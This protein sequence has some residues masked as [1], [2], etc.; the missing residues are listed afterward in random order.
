MSGGDRDAA[1]RP[2]LLPETVASR[3]RAGD[4][5][6]TIARAYGVSRTNVVR[7]LMDAGV[8]TRSPWPELAE[9]LAEH[10]PEIAR[11]YAAG[12]SLATLSRHF[13]LSTERVRRAVLENGGTIRGCN[14]S[15][16]PRA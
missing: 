11:R 4:S 6:R 14:G 10:G 1:A 13:G 2:L 16:T 7:R 3:Y 8:P 12:A 5:L 15:A 9:E